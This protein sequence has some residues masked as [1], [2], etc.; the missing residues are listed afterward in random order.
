[1]LGIMDPEK[2]TPEERARELAR[3]LA[4][5]FLRLR[6]NGPFLADSEVKLEVK[7]PVTSNISNSCLKD[8]SA[9]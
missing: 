2:M 3:I 7:K 1:M 9:S 5:G 8:K 4:Q 6:K